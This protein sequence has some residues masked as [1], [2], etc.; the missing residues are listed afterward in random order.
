MHSSASP[1]ELRGT[2]GEGSVDQQPVDLGLLVARHAEAIRLIEGGKRVGDAVYMHE[3]LLAQQPADIRD[4][5]AAASQLAS[6]TH[7]VF[8]VIR[9]STRR[10]EIAFL[11]YPAFFT[12]PFPVLRASWLVRLSTGQIA[13]SDFSTQD[14]PPILCDSA[15]NFDPLS[16]GIG[17]QN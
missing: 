13:H 6:L 10:P 9:F 11:S 2:T 4:L 7:D 3:A 15:C 17:V 5:A 14:N 16:W 12:D 1:V 8:N